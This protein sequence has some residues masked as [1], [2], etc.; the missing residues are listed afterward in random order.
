MG[1]VEVQNGCGGNA[2]W[3]SNGVG[4]CRGGWE[5]VLGRY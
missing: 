5:G 2:D 1:V 3:R 4:E